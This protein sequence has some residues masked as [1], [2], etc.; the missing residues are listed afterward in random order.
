MNNTTKT[1]RLSDI[2]VGDR[3]NYFASDLFAGVDEYPTLSYPLRGDVV[4]IKHLAND[5]IQ[6]K[7]ATGWLLPYPSSTE[8]EI[9][10]GD[11]TPDVSQVQYTVDKAELF[12]GNE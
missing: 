5:S 6:L 12:R 7:A 4:D 2:Q 3:I 11:F 10:E 1:K 9:I 8:F